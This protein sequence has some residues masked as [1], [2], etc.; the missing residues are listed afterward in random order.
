MARGA[1][2]IKQ[3]SRDGMD[4]GT[5]TVGDATNGHTVANDGK[6][7]ILVKNTGATARIV[8]FK[9]F[10]TVDGQA[11]TPRAK[12]LP[13]GATYLFGPFPTDHYGAQLDIDVAHAEL[14]LQ[15]VRV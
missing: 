3:A 14:T 10:K 4:M 7:G 12:S 13:A 15:A 8:T 11:I 2:S 5:A 6:T 9:L 1:L